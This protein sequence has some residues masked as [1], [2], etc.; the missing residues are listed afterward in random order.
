MLLINNEA[1]KKIEMI[2]QEVFYLIMVP[3]ASSFNKFTYQ[4][5]LCRTFAALIFVLHYL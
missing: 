4:K 3:G 2:L 1:K 5:K